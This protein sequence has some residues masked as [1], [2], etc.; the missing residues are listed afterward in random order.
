MSEQ[1]KT[2]HQQRQFGKDD[3]NPTWIFGNGRVVQKKFET[4]GAL[5]GRL[6]GYTR[7][8]SRETEQIDLVSSVG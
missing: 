6:F 7:F 2:A 1:P 8:I 3:G 5:D 4:L